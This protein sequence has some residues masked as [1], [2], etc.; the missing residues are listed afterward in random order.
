MLIPNT[1]GIEAEARELVVF[2]SVEELK[3]VL[4][5]H[6]GEKVLVVGQGSNL[7]LRGDFDGLVLQSGMTR[8]LSLT[9]DDDYVYIDCGAGIVLDELIAQVAD[10]RLW[11]LENLS[12]IPGTVG[13]SAVQNVGA[14]GIEA[15][16]VITAV[17]TVEIA[18]GEERIWSVEECG[19]GYRESIFKGAEAG[20]YVVTSVTYKLGKTPQP[21][22]GGGANGSRI[23]T[24][25]KTPLQ[26]REEIIATRRQKLPEVSEY[27]S[28]GSYFK[29]P[30]VTV[31]SAKGIMQSY[32]DMPM[33]S[34]PFP[35]GE[36]GTASAGEDRPEVV[37]LS[38]AWL[39]DQCGLKGLQ[40]GGAR[41][42]DKQP[43]VIVNYTGKATAEDIVALAEKVVATVKEKFGVTLTPEVQYV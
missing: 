26:V 8:V 22:T 41:V 21:P 19:Y 27:G 1:F 24:T 14:Y 34:V 3:R 35:F 9:E 23:Q 40:I 38:A 18:T 10:M 17:H 36:E 25:G 31:Q 20:K 15:K 28:A 42:W 16:D 43:L 37:K 7:L 2:Q 32:P 5:A 11:G 29:N 12:Y 33:Y 6:K 13:A 39:I 4:A 30:I